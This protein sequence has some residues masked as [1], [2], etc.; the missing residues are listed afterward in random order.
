MLELDSHVERREGI[1][2]V[3]LVVRNPTDAPRRVRVGNRLDGPV[4]PPRCE[5]VPAAGWDD[6]GFEGVVAARD[7]RALGYASPVT[8]E[9]DDEPA[10]SPP[11]ELVWTE[12]AGASESGT[13]TG[14]FADA[15]TPEGV[16][17]A[18]GDPRPPADAVPVAEPRSAADPAADAD[19]LVPDESETDSSVPEPVEAWLSAVEERADADAR[20]SGPDL[21]PAD[22]NAVGTVADR[23]DALR[24]RSGRSS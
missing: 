20:E 19:P 11:A 15:E 24:R 13:E 17:R 4:W 18:L 12:R 10:V 1:A 6:G 9:R 3:N 23:I 14:S 8:A 5:G 22:R 21:R 2:L 16:V 7:R